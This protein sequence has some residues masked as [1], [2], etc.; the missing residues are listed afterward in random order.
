MAAFSIYSTPVLICYEVFL[1]IQHCFHFYAL[2]SLIQHCFPISMSYL[3]SS[4]IVFS[5]LCAISAC[6]TLFSRF[7]A[8]SLLVQH[9]FLVSMSHFHSFNIDF[10]FLWPNSACSTLFFFFILFFVKK[11][12]IIS[13]VGKQEMCSCSQC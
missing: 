1:F 12:S 2:S 5:F 9:C 4:N 11:G 8:L 3:Y 10:L 13:S 7:Y 6:S